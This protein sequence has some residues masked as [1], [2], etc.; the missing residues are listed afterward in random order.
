MIHRRDPSRATYA[1]F[2]L[3]AMLGVSS[4]SED[5]KAAAQI[6]GPSG[7]PRVDESVLALDI[8]DGVPV[9]ITYLFTLTDIVHLWVRWEGLEP[10]HAAEAVWFDPNGGEAASAVA[11]IVD[12]PA[13]QI[14]DFSLDLTLGST[15]GRWEVVL[16]LDDVLQRSLVFDV[17]DTP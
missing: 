7:G 5:E 3:L 17:F 13:D 11:D 6:V 2:L 9:G 1:A 4:C 10:P 16:Y 12:G 14:T 8:V 15:V